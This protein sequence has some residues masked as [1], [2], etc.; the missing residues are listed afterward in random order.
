MAIACGILLL[1]VLSFLPMMYV[2]GL[3]E[4]NH[5]RW[6]DDHGETFSAIYYPHFLLMKRSEAYFSVATRVFHL[7][8]PSASI[9][10]FAEWAERPMP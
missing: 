3:A 8:N 6:L 5:W 4:R 1:Y 9:P 7:G 10:T 2:A